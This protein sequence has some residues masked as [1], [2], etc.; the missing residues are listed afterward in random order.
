MDG[1]LSIQ[2]T[3]SETTVPD[4]FRSVIRSGETAI[5]SL[6]ATGRYD[7]VYFDEGR[8]V[9]ASSSDADLGLAEVLLCSGELNLQQYEDALEHATGAKKIGTILC[10]RGL[11]SPDDLSRAIERQISSI[12]V[13]AVA[14]RTGSYTLDFSAEFPKDLARLPINTERLL[15]DGIGRIDQ[16]SLIA[17][18]VRRGS[19]VLQQSPDADRRIYHLDLTEEEAHVYALLSEPQGLATLCERSYLSNFL[20]CRIVWALLT[21]NLVQ[22][23]ETEQDNH[24]RDAYQAELQLEAMVERYNGVYQ[25]IFAIVYQ[26][27]GDYVYDF[28]DRIVRHL[29]P[30]VMPYLSGIN[31]INES[32]VDFD[33][34]L[35]NLIASGSEDR[36]PIVAN[37]LNELLYGWIYEI[38]SEFKNELEPQITPLIARLRQ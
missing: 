10:E 17:R 3:L 35:T 29:S 13:H 26:R 18:G 31:L 38:K 1:D 23:S 2:G 4:L 28:L 8:I 32:R 30:D 21:V 20:T 37:V 9:S 36:T 25:A 24:E 15:L 12:V 11:L 14:L 22:Q 27:I 34:L 7:N 33:Q 5:V 19:G 16:W 6:E